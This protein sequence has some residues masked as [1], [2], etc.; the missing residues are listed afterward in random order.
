MRLKLICAVLVG[1]LL[2]APGCGSK[3]KSAST[4][5]MKATTATT[6]TSATG[7]LNLS[8]SD[9]KNLIA[10]ESTI[11]KAISGTLPSDFNAQI[12][13]LNALGKGAPAAVRGDIA[14]LAVAASQIAKLNLPSGQKLTAAQTAQLMQ[15]MSKLNLTKISAAAADLGA[16]AQKAC[17]GK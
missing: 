12:A 8:S 15:A 16:W 1:V 10:A 2:I 9:C 6:T 17:A 3:K 14:T 13:A 4:T 7:G 11:S 5:T